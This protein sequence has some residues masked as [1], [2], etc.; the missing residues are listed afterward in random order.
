MKKFGTHNIY[1]IL[2]WKIIGKYESLIEKSTKNYCYYH[3]AYYFAYEITT[4]MSE[5]YYLG[6]ISIKKKT[7]EKLRHQEGNKLA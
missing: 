6:I 4:N 1:I 7:V 3:Q 5:I 2:K